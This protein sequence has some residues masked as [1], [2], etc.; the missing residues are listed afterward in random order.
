MDKDWIAAFFA[1]LLGFGPTSSSTPPGPAPEHTIPAKGVAPVQR[2]PQSPVECVLQVSRTPSSAVLTAYATA[3]NRAQAG[4]YR[5]V[6]VK[7]HGSNRATISQAGAFDLVPGRSTALGQVTLGSSELGFSA[8]ATLD[9]DGGHTTCRQGL[10]TPHATALDK[11]VGKPA[12]RRPR[13]HARPDTVLGMDESTFVTVDGQGN[14]SSVTMAGS[15]NSV[16]IHQSN[17]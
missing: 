13:R 1:A 6:M 3:N 17:D 4:S 2:S 11:S 14:E 10:A 7:R 15:G 8:D 12:I 9:W 5:L 16:S